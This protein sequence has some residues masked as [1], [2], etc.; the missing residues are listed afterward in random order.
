MMDTH[1]NMKKEPLRKREIDTS[2][3][4]KEEKFYEKEIEK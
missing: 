3:K 4:M 1:Y 2:C